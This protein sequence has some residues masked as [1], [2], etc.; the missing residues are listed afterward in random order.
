MLGAALGGVLLLCAPS[1]PAGECDLRLHVT[2]GGGDSRLWQ[3]SIHVSAGECQQLRNLGLES[4]APTA[5]EVEPGGFRF[6][7]NNPVSFDGF[8]VRVSSARD[9]QLAVQISNDA[10]AANPQRFEVPLARLAAE[11]DFTFK[12]ALADQKNWLFI[13][14][15]PGDYL[16]VVFP[17]D[18]LVFAGGE[19]LSF[20]VEGNALP[21]AADTVLR[22]SMHLQ[23]SGRD[24]E[25]WKEQRELR[26]LAG[27]AADRIGPVR[28]QLPAEEGVYDLVLALQ[29]RGFT[30]SLGSIVRPKELLQ[31][32]VQL[33]VLGSEP[34]SAAAAEEWREVE[35]M[36]L[37]SREW[38]KRWNWLP[39]LKRL[40][41]MDSVTR[42]SEAT[43]L[44][45]GPLEKRPYAS[46]ELLKLAGNGWYAAPI[47]ITRMG[48]PHLLE[49]E[50]PSDV[51]QTLGISV[52]ETNAA[53]AVTPLGIDSGIDVPERRSRGEGQLEV[54]RLL[55]WPR[56]RTPWLLLTN[57]R[58]ND[59]AMFGRI[60]VL[61]GPKALPAAPAGG[62]STA[63]R[64]LAMYYDKPL[65][66]ENFS[67]PEA[68]DAVSGRSLEDWNTFYL[69]GRRLVEYA[70]YTGY[71]AAMISV[72]R[73]GGAIYPS[74]LVPTTPKFDTGVFFSSGQ[75]PVQKDVLELLYRLFD[76][77]GLRLIPALQL[78]SPLPELQHLI[79]EGGRDAVGIELVGMPEGGARP[80]AGQ[81][82]GRRGAAPYYNPLDPRVQAAVGRVVQELTQRY[83]HH[84]SFAG[85]CLQLGPETYTVLP[86]DGW[87]CDDHTIARFEQETGLQLPGEAAERFAVRARYL[88]T[89]AHE[90]WLTWRKN[91]LARF[92]EILQRD[93]ARRRPEARLYLAGEAL[94]TGWP[95]QSELRPRVL[96]SADLGRVLLRHGLDP[97]ALNERQVSFFRPQRYA[98]ATSLVAQSM[99]VALCRSAEADAYF[100]GPPAGALNY[101]EPLTLRL[102]EFD[103]QS[104]FGS[105]R[106]YTWLAAQIP[107]SGADARAPL[108]RSIAA[109]DAHIA[110]QGGWAVPLGQE[111][112][113]RN[114]HQ[115][116][117]QLPAAP[118]SNSA[119]RSP[120]ALGSDVVVRTLVQ[121]N[122]TWLYV[123]NDSGWTTIVD[124]QLTGAQRVGLHSLGGRPLPR[125]EQQG[126]T[127]S[128]TLELPPYDLLAVV[129]QSPGVTVKDWRVSYA[130]QVE[131]ELEELV[132]EVKSRVNE[133]RRPEPLEVLTN[134][135]FETP[136]DNGVIPGWSAAQRPG[137]LI[138]TD[139]RK[140]RGGK[141]C[142]RM[143]VDQPGSVAWIRSKPFTPPSTGRIFVLAWIRTG[144]P[145]RQPPVRLAIDGRVGNEPYYRFAPLGTDVDSQT[146]RPTG[147][148]AQPLSADWS[149][150]PFLLPIDDLPVSGISELLVGFDLMGPGEVW[151]DDVQVF[152][153]YFQVNEQDELLKDAAMAGFLLKNGQLAEC[154]RYLSSYWPRFL[155]EYVPPPQHFASLN[156]QADRA[157]SDHRGPEAKSETDPSGWTRLIPRVPLRAPFRK[158]GGGRER[159]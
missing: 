138:E 45:S 67:A 9:A 93:I 124:L 72:L 119:S 139:S 60:R 51:R 13:R 132:N 111:E 82:L 31:Q 148:P 125:L 116:F 130:G 8:E 115:V 153:L 27:G 46:R 110:V 131:R 159:N 55:F 113:V 35:I 91:E 136:G 129:F 26:V 78:A 66:P 158:N 143:R 106:T 16:R 15:A 81:Q 150:R 88:R 128:W 84:S 21:M 141:H 87:P 117:R 123:V 112:A 100:R 47:P 68:L 144:D 29:Q 107:P 95:A 19:E 41:G 103:K 50:Y 71:N 109:L 127:S 70:R 6:W 76:R 142:L 38:W 53:G 24:D 36:E 3:G 63:E 149:D 94:L 152:D 43:P 105:D 34:P 73:D 33:V 85:V 155:L 74:T 157:A 140:P 79:R 14:R 96:Q 97:L 102:A 61:A 10:A 25:L 83:G 69:G 99:N 5:V 101:H 135:G 18:A 92:Y 156:D 48:Q 137:V 49:V 75:D 145:Q 121:G 56:T 133:L 7:Q 23:T 28:L 134:A 11:Q 114:L 42:V 32:R 57:R 54:H 59:P 151:I 80:V 52:L 40:P 147:Q 77:E 154:G 122:Q 22:L 120:S 1:L 4:D 126:E 30:P 37:T 118:F 90:Q 86:D 17:R 2:W 89:T 104:P 12:A 64:L 65:F 20:Q 98:P 39:H 58:A 108:V 62:G 44:G 146:G